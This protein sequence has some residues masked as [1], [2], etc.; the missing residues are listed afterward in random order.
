M[1]LN[2]EQRERIKKILS[3]KLREKIAVFAEQE[4]MYKP[5][6]ISLFSKEIVFAGSLL[7]SIYTW[8]GGKWEEI[9]EILAS[10]VFPKVERRYRLEGEITPRE[11]AKIDD[12]LK[13]L[14]L[15]VREIS[16][17]KVKRELLDSFGQDDARRKTSETVDLFLEVGGKEF[18]IELK[19]VKPNK[20][21][22]E[23]PNKTCSMS[24]Q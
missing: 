1:P 4:D 17:E 20:M 23:Q 18:Y 2:A 10:G 5:F 7:Q 14:E 3:S 9:A 6:Y 13:D 15:S 8:L 24:W 22:C 21:K 12:I 16:I 19:S 11:Q